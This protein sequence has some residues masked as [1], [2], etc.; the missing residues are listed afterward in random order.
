MLFLIEWML[1][2]GLLHQFFCGRWYLWRL[3][4]SIGLFLFIGICLD[5]SICCVNM[6]VYGS[7]PWGVFF[8]LVW[9]SLWV[10]GC[11]SFECVS[12]FRNGYFLFFG[13]SLCSLFLFLIFFPLIFSFSFSFSFFGGLICQSYLFCPVFFVFFF[14]SFI[15]F[16]ILPIGIVLSW[17]KVLWFPL[18]LPG[19][20]LGI[21]IMCISVFLKFYLSF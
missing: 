15:S 13:V 8:S 3:I 19:L 17:E 14:L 1:L 18:I 9:F 7:V 4:F 10:W 6:Y 12:L 11:C 20:F 21:Y 5:N 16:L 2:F